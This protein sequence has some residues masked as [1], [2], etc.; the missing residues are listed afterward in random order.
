MAN[1]APAERPSAP[2]AGK[3]I[4]HGGKLTGTTTLLLVHRSAT[5]SA[6]ASTYILKVEDT[7]K[8]SYVS[9]LWDG[10]SAG[11]YF[12]EFKGVRYSMTMTEDT[13]EVVPVA[14]GTPPYINR[15][16]GNSIAA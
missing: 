13:A 2:L 10:P 1:I 3:Y 4:R 6:K 12:L 14:G 7:G 16:S 11:T 15:G 9:S 5:T 8:R